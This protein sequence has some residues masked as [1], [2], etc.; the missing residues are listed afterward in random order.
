MKFFEKTLD[1]IYEIVYE[2]NEQLFEQ[3]CDEKDFPIIGVFFEFT[4]WA[5]TF[6][7]NDEVLFTS[8]CCAQEYLGDELDCYEDVKVTLIRSINQKLDIYKKITLK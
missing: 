6:K 1:E 2:V 4:D 3:T 7:L 8:E 5:A